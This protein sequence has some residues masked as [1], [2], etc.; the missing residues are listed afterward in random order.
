MDPSTLAPAAIVQVI[1]VW[2][3]QKLKTSKA[4][5]WL[6]QYTPIANRIIA[7]VIAMVSAAGITWHYNA[8]LGQLTVMGLTEQAIWTALAGLVTNELTY[9]L[10]QIKQQA[11]STGRTV[12]APPIAEPPAVPQEAKPPV[13]QRVMSA[14]VSANLPK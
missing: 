7:V 8:T 6:S 13:A 2:L 11:L 4:F 14:P 10:V 3:I 12:G 1:A 5:P 9:A